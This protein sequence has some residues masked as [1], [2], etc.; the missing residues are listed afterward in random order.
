MA[1]GDVPLFESGLRVPPGPTPGLQPV[2][3]PSPSLAGIGDAVSK[4]GEAGSTY[5]AHLAKGQAETDDA[6]IKSDYLTQLAGLRE[7]YTRSE[8]YRTAPGAFEDNRAVLEKD[9]LGTVRDPLRRSALQLFM[10]SHGLSAS[11][12]VTTKQLANEADF[13]VAGLNDRSAVYVRDA[14]VAG[15]PPERQGVIDRWNADVDAQVAAGWISR[16]DAVQRKVT[17]L[18]TL[19]DAAAIALT[20]IN[21]RQAAIELQDP[22]KFKSLGPVMRQNLINQAQA[23]ADTVMVA[24]LQSTAQR[25]PG[26]AVASIGLVGR[27]E[28]ADAVFSRGIMPTENAAGDNTLESPKGAV[29]VTQILPGTARDVAKHLGLN[30]FDGLDD[31]A[32]KQ[33]LKDD[34]NLNVRLGTTYWRGMVAR[35]D[36]RID[37]AAAAY[38]AGPGRA[39]KWVQEAVR[40]YG[41]QFSPAE[42]VSLIDIKETRD[43]VGKVRARLGAPLDDGLS[44]VA[45]Y[46]AANAVGSAMTAQDNERLSAIKAIAAI[47]RENDEPAAV[48]KAGFEV[49]PVKYAAWKQTQLLAAQAGDMASAK[50]YR[51]AEFQREMLPFR[52]KALRTAPAELENFVDGET[53]RLAGLP[54]VP[55]DTKNRLDVAREVLKSVKTARDEN[56]IGLAEHAQLIPPGQRV[57]LDPAGDPRT[58][59]FRA[60]LSARGV[61]A[62]D[63]ARFYQGKAIAFKPQEL[64]GMKER[65]ANAAADERFNLLEA[66]GVS[67]TGQAYTE[68][69]HA[70]AGN[71]DIVQTVGQLA[72]GRPE[73]AREVLRGDELL[74]S[75]EVSEK[76]SLVKPAFAATLGGQIYVPAQQKSVEDA[77]LRLYVARAGADGTLY[78]P[79]DTAGIEKAVTDITGPIIKRNGARVPISPGLD[80]GRFEGALN[81]LSQADLD[82]MGGAQGAHGAA[83]GAADISRFG[84]LK[85]LAPGSTRYFVGMRDR[86]AP[87]GFAPIHTQGDPP[88]PL[89]LDMAALSKRYA[90]VYVPGQGNRSSAEFR[91]GQ[92]ERIRSDREAAGP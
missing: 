77:A 16:K 90:P 70:I 10:T 39:D 46:H 72:R 17:G 8:D 54:D 78:D 12:E 61:Q 5:A 83:L 74:K 52:Q 80:R 32:V 55:I 67:L 9:L 89:I 62:N 31:A 58:P 68:T 24:T 56:I 40:N 7:A 37:A 60:M 20:R 42:F 69:L 50:A 63:G 76:S 38:N 22:E 28:Q 92:A 84:V 88:S 6:K 86:N 87:D 53:A 65:W 23:Q 29:G 79:A 25:D 3:A 51:E 2:T 19:D 81:N 41:A 43:Y 34:E 26:R 59:A 27:P 18:Q 49:D 15:S 35:Y 14:A 11:K 33:K 4:L 57:A 44:P 13:N 21:P 48:F 1:A 73:L 66:F 75:K 91:A 85:P 64:T 45:R 47:G 36:G 71:S 30:V 82:S